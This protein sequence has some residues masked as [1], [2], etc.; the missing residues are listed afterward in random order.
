[1]GNEFVA[2]A[3]GSVHGLALVSP[4]DPVEQ[5]EEL[6]GKVDALVDEGKL[7]KG[8]A[9]ALN[10]KLDSA[11]KSIEKGK[12]NTACN[13]LGAFINQVN[14]LINSGRL[15]LVEGEPLIFAAEA[16]ITALSV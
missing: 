5:I 7:N 3:A 1:V 14:A 6:I 2:I 10:S 11:L 8:E 4:P 12:T 15:T 9:N 13:Q 16:V